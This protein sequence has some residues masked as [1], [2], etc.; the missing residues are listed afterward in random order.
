M[1]ARHKYKMSLK[2]RIWLN[3]NN[4][5]WAHE[6]GKEYS[7]F[8]IQLDQIFFRKSLDC[9]QNDE[10]TDVLSILDPD[11]DKEEMERILDCIDDSPADLER[12]D[13]FGN[14]VNAA[15]RTDVLESL[16]LRLKQ[17][18]GMAAENLLFVLWQMTH[19]DSANGL[20]EYIQSDTATFEGIEIAMSTLECLAD[21]G[22]P[23]R[24]KQ[25]LRGNTASMVLG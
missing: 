25:E 12:L 13:M 8:S 11:L 20:V 18:S 5:R 15:K 24:S 23:D 14:V 16:L 6:E 21:E 2:T 22:K 1:N 10:A 9:G 17:S 7:D 3:R 19:P 4:S